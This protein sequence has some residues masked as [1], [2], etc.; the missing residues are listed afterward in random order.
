MRSRSL[1]V[2]AVE[3]LT[4]EAGAATNHSLGAAHARNN[5]RIP[6]LRRNCGGTSGVFAM[7]CAVGS[8]CAGFARKPAHTALTCAYR[9]QPARPAMIGCVDPRMATAAQPGR[10]NLP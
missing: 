10:S 8:V 2:S 5:L 3:A 6:H 4:K 7:T 1:A 9:P